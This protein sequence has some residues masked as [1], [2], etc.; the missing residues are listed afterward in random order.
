M[1]RDQTLRPRY[2]SAT[3]LP[4][5]EKAV[6]QTSSRSRRI[7]RALRGSVETQCVRSSSASAAKIK[8]RT[9][10]IDTSEGSIGRAV[11]MQSIQQAAGILRRAQ[12][13]RSLFHGHEVGFGD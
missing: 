2:F 9:E 7:R 11:A 1:R 13:I 10:L 3:G 6:R 4:V 5:P 12:Q 8:L